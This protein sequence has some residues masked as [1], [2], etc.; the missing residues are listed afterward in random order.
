MNCRIAVLVTLAAGPLL[1]GQQEETPTTR[2][3]KNSEA[4][5]IFYLN[6]DIADSV[7]T[8]PPPYVPP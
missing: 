3:M 2:L 5:Q 1:F 7:R 4:D 8:P 6:N